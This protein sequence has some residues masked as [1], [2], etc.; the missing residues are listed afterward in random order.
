[1]MSY[2]VIG[3]CIFLLLTVIIISIK[4]ISMGI[5]ARRDLKEN[6]EDKEGINDDI[7]DE[8]KSK[9]LNND[10]FISDEIVKLNKLRE[11]GVLSEEEYVKAKN[12]L[13]D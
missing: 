7:I 13:L 8:D 12:K 9:L 2:L 4:P 1:M 10:L 6:L 3:L 5:E 11:D